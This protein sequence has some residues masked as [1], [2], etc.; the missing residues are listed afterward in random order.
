MV[1][2]IG[3]VLSDPW[4]NCSTRMNGGYELFVIMNGI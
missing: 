4:L 3:L 1:M 2:G